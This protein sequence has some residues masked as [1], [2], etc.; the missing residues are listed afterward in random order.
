MDK[1]YLRAKDAAEYVGIGVN[2]MR[3]LLNS[4]DP[5]PYLMVG[6]EKRVQKAALA[7]YFE[8]RQEVRMR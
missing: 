3:D 7:E 4:D 5:P 1:L 2:A 8:R 6:K